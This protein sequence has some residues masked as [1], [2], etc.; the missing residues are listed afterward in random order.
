MSCHV[1]LSVLRMIYLEIFL[2]FPGTISIQMT[3]SIYKFRPSAKAEAKLFMVL[4]SKVRCKT[5]EASEICLNQQ[6][7]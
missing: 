3:L 2:L 7:V 6:L 4:A 1:L 5:T